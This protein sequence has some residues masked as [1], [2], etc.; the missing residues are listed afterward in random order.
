M[1]IQNDHIKIADDIAYREEEHS[2]N[3]KQ[4]KDFKN[5]TIMLSEADTI[6]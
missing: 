1:E 3:Q 4:I 2:S 5:D 6:E